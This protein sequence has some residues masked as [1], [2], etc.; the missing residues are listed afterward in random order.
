MRAITIRQPWA[1]LIV[2]GDKDVENRSWRTRHRGPLLIHA[3]AR[4]DR[5]LLEQHGVTGEVELGAIIGVVDVVDC[6]PDRTS[7]WHEEGAWGWY[8]AR[9]KRFRKPIPMKG[10]RGL[11]DV[12]DRK[13]A[14]QLGGRKGASRTAARSRARGPTGSRS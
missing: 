4:A 9:P 12:P 1:E 2:R 8:L 11:F 13:V 7:A 10:R 5:G 3:G 14:S 6:T